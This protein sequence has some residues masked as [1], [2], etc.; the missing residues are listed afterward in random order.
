MDVVTN[1]ILGSKFDLTVLLPEIFVLTM[2]VVILLNDCFSK[3]KA[4]SAGHNNDTFF[5]SLMGVFGAAFLILIGYGKFAMTYWDGQFLRASY[6]DL[7]KMLSLIIVGLGFIYSRKNLIQG[8]LY[9]AEFYI[10]ALL[11]SLG[12][13][14]LISAASLLT[15]YL[16]LE[17][18]SLSMY[19]MVAFNKNNTKSTEAAMKYFVMGAMASG[20][21]LYGMALVYGATG[22]IY[23][24]DIASNMPKVLS[25]ALTNKAILMVGIIFLITGVAFKFGAVPYHSWVPD[26]YEGAPNSVAI[27]VSTAPKLAAIAMAMAL[28]HNASGALIHEWSQMVAVVCILSFAVGNLVALMQTNIKRMLAYSAIS[29]VGF[30]LLGIVA[31]DI[32]SSIFYGI[33]YALTTLAAFGILMALNKKGLEIDQI[34][35]LKG[36]SSTHP[37]FAFLMLCVMF[38]MA[39]VPPLVGFTA[40]FTILMSVYAAGMLPVV[41]IALLFSVI[42]LFYYLRVVKVMYFDKADNNIVTSDASGIVSTLLSINSLGLIWLG[43]YPAALFALLQ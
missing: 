41:I 40:K 42:G 30:I 3:K 15:I 23:I 26:V 35:D 18:M 28:L 8:G 13:M 39:G 32:S 17:L 33:T 11:G 34:S 25:G 27:Y 29:H 38:S 37:W 7:L 20:I 22:S 4:D 19:A 12:M 43:I 9:K 21:L 31:N 2:V 10:L 1:N 14:V 36:L 5:L 24:A 6:L 16:G